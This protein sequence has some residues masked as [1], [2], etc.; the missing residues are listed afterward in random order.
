MSIE[1]LFE[2]LVVANEKT[3]A[4]L[5]KIAGVVSVPVPA[6]TPAES[7]PAETKKKA[8]KPASISKDEK[9]AATDAEVVKDEKKGNTAPADDF[10]DEKE[11]KAATEDEMRAALQAYAAANNKDGQGT[12]RAKALLDKVAGVKKVADCPKDKYQAVIDATKPS[13]DEEDL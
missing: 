7:K 1:S 2:R 10:L 11:K 3:A 12:A 13:A 5:E 9:A 4:A 6:G 8:S